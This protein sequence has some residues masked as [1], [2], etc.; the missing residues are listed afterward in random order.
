MGDLKGH[1]IP[2]SFFLLY[3]LWC[4]V[5][6]L[7]KYFISRRQGQAYVTTATHKLSCCPGKVSRLPVEPTVKVLLSAGGLMGELLA[8][9]PVPPMGIV[10]HATMYLFF[11]LSGVTD[12][13]VHFGL[14]LPHGTDFISLVLALLIEG[15]LFASH[16]H[17]RPELDVQLHML[18]VYV[19]FTTAVVIALEIKF[20]N[21]A[22]LSMARAYLM[23]LQGSWFW[24][25]GVI[26]YAHGE[27]N[28]AWALDN[29]ESSMQAA[30][31]FSWHCAGHVIVLL[32]LTAL[33]SLCYRKQGES[34]LHM[35]LNSLEPEVNSSKEGY[36]IL[37]WTDADDDSD[38]VLRQAMM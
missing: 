33:M 26:L 34:T 1:A 31:Y 35:E 9:L 6:C 19:I 14:P 13:G 8:H 29:P 2:G 16:V 11:L 22:L 32:V 36:G 27:P 5:G 30:I 12:L 23:M 4:A 25:V 38:E 20:S 28:T 15:L 10:Q 18:L 17:G 21:S 3:G 24:A 37:A 7:R